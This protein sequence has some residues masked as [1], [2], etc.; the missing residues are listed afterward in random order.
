MYTQYSEKKN[1][2]I[3]NRANAGDVNRIIQLSQQFHVV[4]PATEMSE[5]ARRP[6]S[7]VVRRYYTSW[8][9]H[10]SRKQTLPRCCRIRWRHHSP[11]SACLGLLQLTFYGI[12][13]GL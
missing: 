8:W 2:L 9:L 4:G 7:L 10:G 6:R 13:D 12:S 1:C 3:G 5:K 11:M